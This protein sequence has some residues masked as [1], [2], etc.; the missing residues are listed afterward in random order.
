MYKLLLFF[1]FSPF[2]TFAQTSGKVWTEIGV[3]GEI[4]KKLDWGVELNTRFGSNGIETYFPQVT[5]KYKVTKWFRPSVDYRA[6]FDREDNGNYS[7]SNRL[8]FNANFK[9]LVK[10]FTIGG[11]VRYQ[12]AFN[13]FININ[14]F[15]AEFDQAIRFKPEITYDI[16]NSIFSPTASIE[17][18]YNPNY[19]P[20]GQRFTKYRAFIGVDLELDGP[21]DISFGYLFDQR[22]QVPNP[23]TRHVLSLSYAY[24]LGGKK[25]KK[26]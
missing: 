12:Y 4:T 11:R 26:K 13:R 6:I 17:F 8:N 5:L 7:F 21:H 3:K 22:I 16:N 18:F 23:K 10:R 1:C 19:G 9:F 14:E 25:K 2:L 15:D 20:Y 24:K